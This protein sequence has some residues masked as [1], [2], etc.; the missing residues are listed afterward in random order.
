M[1][2]SMGMMN[3]KLAAAVTGIALAAGLIGCTQHTSEPS[4]LDLVTVTGQLGQTPVVDFPAPLN[5]PDILSRTVIHGDEAPLVADQIIEAAIAQYSGADGLTL[6]TNGFSPNAP[7]RVPLTEGQSPEWLLDIMIGSSVGDRIVFTVPLLELGAT[8]SLLASEGLPITSSSIFVLDILKAY[9]PKADG[10]DQMVT[11]NR[12]PSVSYAP[13]GT[14]GLTFRDTEAPTELTQVLLKKGNRQII[15][16]T[17]SVLVH[18][19]MW[20]WDDRRVTGTSWP[21]NTPYLVP[22]DTGIYEIPSE[23]LIG[24]SIGS[25]IMIVHPAEGTNDAWIIIADL[26]GTS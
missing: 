3:K 6:A 13:N 17:D 9:L 25:Q 16:S 12:L 26:L 8:E 19:Q 1:K 2:E 23:A 21:S 4:A 14:P 7:V 24:Q 22:A 5:T 11:D 10:A 18:Y 20:D 15:E